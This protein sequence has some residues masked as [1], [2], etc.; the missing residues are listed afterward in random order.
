MTTMYASDAAANLRLRPAPL[1]SVETALSG[2]LRSCPAEL[3]DGWMMHAAALR[4]GFSTLLFPGQALMAF[5]GENHTDGVAFAHGVPNSTWLSSA[6]LMQDK[7]MRRDVLAAAGV[8]VPRGRSFSLKR[9]TPYAL[10]YAGA[11]GYPVVVKPMVGESTVEVMSGIAGPDELLQAIKYL[12]TVPTERRDFTTSSYA[13]TQILTPKTG[14]STR[15]RGTYRYLVEEQIHGQYLRLLMAGGRIL[16]AV[17]APAGPWASGS[18]AKDVTEHL[19]PGLEAFAEQVWGALPGLAVLAVDVVVEDYTADPRSGRPPVVVDAA[20]R[21]W[22]YLQHEVAPQK[23]E[24]LGDELFHSAAADA[25][26]NV[27]RSSRRDEVEASFRW[28]GLS[29]VPQDVQT[30]SRAAAG[31]DLQLEVVSEDA[32][33]GVVTGEIRGSAEA[34]AML[35]ELLLEG[36]LLR[37]PAMAV[38][39][40]PR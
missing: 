33:S 37:D 14:S 9:G 13:F 19:H 5:H 8:A 12:R 27:P 31:A 23:T 1:R 22:T 3:F 18:E 30:L 29:H 10:E 32:V 28:E 16:S 6:T 2:P 17:Y 21:P 40:H 20:E 34:L 4:Q 25:S 24:L 11:I 7:R 35:G 38:E 26:V 15:T 39:M 36:D